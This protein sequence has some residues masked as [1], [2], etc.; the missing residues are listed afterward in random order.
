[1]VRA[2]QERDDQIVSLS[3]PGPLPARNHW[4]VRVMSRSV[5][6]DTV[7]LRALNGKLD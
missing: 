1:M 3:Y 2:G 4:L 5:K 6:I 7:R